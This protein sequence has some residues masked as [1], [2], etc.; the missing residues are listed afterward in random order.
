MP[1][2]R[3]LL[4]FDIDGTLITSGGAGQAALRH[5]M[6][7]AFG[8]EEDLSGTIVAGNTDSGIARELLQKHGLPAS[9]ENIASLLDAYLHQLPQR[10]S[11]HRG[12]LLPGIRELLEDLRG[13]PEFLVA[14]LTGNL[15][16]GA[17]IKL[18]HFGVWEFFEFG[19]YAD[20]HH[21]RNEL[22]PVARLRA[23]D[24]HGEDFPPERIYVIGDTPRDIACGKA[25]GAKTMA[26]ATGD[27][28]LDELASCGPDL[29][30][31]DLGDTPAVIRALQNG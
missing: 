11:L 16:R 9:P 26:V 31:S 14:L 22:G 20:D 15:A 4:L 7:D 25:I 24:S 10:L 19:A 17:R 1:I 21:D 29:L 2:E 5:A 18:G 23:L 30:F 6:R 13:R 8:V 3:K 12:A 27:Y 28:P